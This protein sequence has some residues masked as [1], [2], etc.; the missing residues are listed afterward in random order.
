[1]GRIGRVRERM[2]RGG[3]H[4]LQPPR[5]VHVL[6]PAV[7]PTSW[8]GVIGGR[9]TGRVRDAVVDWAEDGARG[10]LA[11]VNRTV[12]IGVRCGNGRPEVR[13]THSERVQSEARGLKERWLTTSAAVANTRVLLE[14]FVI[15]RGAPPAIPFQKGKG[16]H[17]DGET[18]NDS[19]D[20]ERRTDSAFIGKKAFGNG[21]RGSGSGDGKRRA[22]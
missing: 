17:H 22:S 5:M 13:S 4:G 8:G 7:T 16:A 21:T 18:G 19:N 6:L 15:S 2:G 9:P 3:G 11:V 10:G 1:M 14:E 12:W 20:A